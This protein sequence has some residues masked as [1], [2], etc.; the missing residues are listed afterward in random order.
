VIDNRS[1]RYVLRPGIATLTARDLIE[2]P[3]TAR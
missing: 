3:N 1:I 2:Q